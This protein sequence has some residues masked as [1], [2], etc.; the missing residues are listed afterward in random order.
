MKYIVY[1]TTNIINNKIYIGVHKTENPDEFDGYLGCGVSIYDRHTYLKRDYPICLAIRKYGIENFCREVL[2]VFDTLQEALNKEAEIVNEDFIQNRNNYNVALG[3]G[4]PPAQTRE[5]YQYDMNGNYIQSYKSIMDVSRK[6]NIYGSCIGQ[7]VDNKTPSVGFL[8]SDKKYDKLDISQ[9][10]IDENK[11][12]VLVFNVD[13]VLEK[14]FKS[15][16]DCAK[17]IGCYISTITRHIVSQKPYKGYIIRWNG[18]E[19]VT[20][21]SISKARKVGQYDLEG[22]LIKVY[23]SVREAKKFASGVPL[24]LG[25]RDKTAKGFMWKYIDD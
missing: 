17:F 2:F 25:G 24:V 7:A 16:T 5:V 20:E 10:R 13:N 4:V 8:W 6:F 18:E 9:Y 15:L 14:E 22:N 23:R 21:Y 1:K 19:K 3:G 12:S 11:K